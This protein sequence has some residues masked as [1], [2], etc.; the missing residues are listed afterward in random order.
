MSTETNNNL[1][2]GC[3]KPFKSTDNIKTSNFKKYHEQCFSQDLNC[4]KC[5]GPIIASA[6]HK[7]VLGK[8][9]HSKCFT[10]A[11]C[12]KVLSDNDF[13]EISGIPCCKS[14]FTEIKFNPNFAI[15]KFGSASAITQNDEKTKEK[16]EM[17]TNLYNNLQKGKDI[18]TWC[19][20]QIQADP[21][22]EAVSFGGNIYHSNCFTCSKCSS[23]IGKNQ[24]VTG[25]DG[26]AIC[27]SCSDKSK[28]VNCFACKKPIDSTFTVV[29]GNKY[30]PN[31]F[32][33]SQCKGSLEKGYIEK[34]GPVCGKCAATFTQ[35]QTRT[36]AYSNGKGARPNGRW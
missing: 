5:S 34:D 13:S 36:F 7:Q 11:S 17:K 21:D 25:S 16:F 28:Q 12:S 32:V 15:S 22:N 9:Y 27:K 1:C 19:R 31:C 6:E 35:P 2:I 23:S 8:I 24:F 4:S 18:C 33:C 26:S 29:S 20:N 10:C 14:C 3:N 30:H